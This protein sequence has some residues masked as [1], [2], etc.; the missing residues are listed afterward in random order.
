MKKVLITLTAFMLLAMLLP[1]QKGYEFPDSVDYKKNV[2][3]WNLTPFL[4]WSYKNINIGYERV[5]SPYR[6][7]SV[8]A[9]YFELPS[10][11]KGIFDSLNI[12]RSTKKGGFT[13]SGDYRFYF[14][15]RNKRMAPDGLYWGVFA[16]FHHYEFENSIT[17]IDSPVIE[18]DLR[19]GAKAN[20]FSAGVELGY[21]FIIKERLS[22]DLVF[23]GPA[24]TGYGMTLKLGGAV[25]VE[26][27]DRYLQAIYDYLN[28]TIPGFDQLVTEGETAVSGT[29][30]SMGFGLRYLI[31]IGYRF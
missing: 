19:F 28:S 4:I 16:S 22:I 8:N 23:M 18:G 1:A 24:L 7:F 2:I 3:R 17:V 15:K 6:S 29:N 30:I 14:M 10:L 12:D 25:E 31:Q 21:Q 11:T 20:I 27:E 9:G 13:V 5:V 26:E